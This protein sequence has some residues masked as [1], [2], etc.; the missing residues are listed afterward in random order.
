MEGGYPSEV[1]D[2]AIDY[3]K[4]FGYINDKQYALDYIA[5][6]KERHSKKEIYL[7]L[8]QTGIA[9]E[10]LDSAF[11]ESYGSYSDSR[12][13][14]SF[15]E[16]ELVVKTLKKRGFTGSET[17]EEKQK[18]LAYFYRRGFDMDLV[19]SAMDEIKHE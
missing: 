2:I 11:S 14:A 8:S 15:D 10:T 17:Y 12:K 19:F 3:V 18:M 1:I 7:K 4:S 6:D 5:M 16:M 13:E 9:K